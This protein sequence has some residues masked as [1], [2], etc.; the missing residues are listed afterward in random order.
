M[1]LKKLFKINL[2]LISD[3]V[4]ITLSIILGFYLYKIL[5]IDYSSLKIYDYLPLIIFSPIIYF[6]FGL[7]S[8][9]CYSLIAESKKIIYSI[10]TIFAFF[11]TYTFLS[12][13]TEDFSTT[14]PC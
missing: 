10:L 2:L 12:K 8:T 14:V 9:V 3:L 1:E 4:S 11:A 7:Y 13:E 5:N 6:F